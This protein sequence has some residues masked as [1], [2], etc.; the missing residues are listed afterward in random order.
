MATVAYHIKDIRNLALAGH[1]A[2]A[3]TSLVDALLFAAGATDRRGSVD[4][5]TSLS[6]V[7]DEEKRRHFTIDCHLLHLE[8]KGK[9]VHLIDSPGYPD[10]IG[11]ALSALAAVENVLVTVSA[12]AGIEVNTRR[13]FQEAGRLGLGRFIALTKMDAENVD[14]AKDLTAIRE[15]FGAICVP[16]NLP[17][18]QGPTFSAIIDALAPPAE[19][20]AGCPMQPS[21]AYTMV[22][23]QIVELDEGLMARYL[24][25]ETIPA[26]ELRASAHQAVAAGKLVPVVCVS[27]RKDIGLRELLDLIGECGLSPDEVH[28]FGTRGEEGDIE[29]EPHEDGELIAQVFK[30]A[31]DPF[32]GKLSY[33][34]IVSGHM[35]HDA[36]LVNLR[37]GKTSRPGHLYRLQ[38]KTQEEV[39]EAIAGDIVAVPKFDDLHVSDTVAGS[40]SNGQAPLVLK[41]IKFPTPMVPRAVE[42]KTRED[43]PKISAGLAKIADEDPTFTYRRDAQTHELVVS[44]MSDLHLDVILSRLKSRYKLDVN[45]HVPHVPYLETIV[46]QAEA[47]HRHKKQTGGRGQ[48]AEV[49][50][51]IRPR[52]RGAG[53]NFV[54]AVKGG[55]IPN[56]F[57]P[58]VE[59][60][61]KEQL[62]KGVISGNQVVDVEAEV[63][64]GKAHDV[65][66]SEQAFKTA[67][68]SAFRKAFEQARPALLEPIVTIEV[69]VPSAKFGDITADLSTRRGHVTGMDTLPG[70][71]QVIQATVPL[72]EVLNYATNLKSMTGGQGSY[73][74]DFKSYEPVPPNVQQQ[75]VE[76]YMKSR[77]GIEE[78]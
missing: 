37:T 9:Q 2:S 75:I 17:V 18:G 41:P 42:P 1:G 73:T 64:F 74:M 6:D 58:A 54:D 8:W 48:F 36:T 12:P 44:G 33:L 20:P 67:S 30:T 3:K 7:E 51:R 46:G 56:Q 39:K 53:F 68:A 10:F 35:T 77:A 5:G 55:V 63:Y 25:G 21:E 29:I 49:H 22:V 57:I 61:I 43:E 28:R 16:F 78:E 59:K 40:N 15:T 14:Y 66:S 60:G 4:D 38:G 70:G 72:S 27:T 13:V 23:E 47:S 26:D 76:R 50:L 34:R 62:E 24:E 52:E 65:D 45:T 31:I 19:V 11:N 69:T 71:L 32:M